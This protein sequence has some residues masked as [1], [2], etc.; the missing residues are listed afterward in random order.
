MSALRVEVPL[1]TA[2]Q[3]NCNHSNFA[4]TAS[5]TWAAP[6]SGALLSNSIVMANASS[7]LPDLADQITTYFSQPTPPASTR[8]IYL[9]SFGLW[10]IYSHA[11]LP[12][13]E[14]YNATITS[15]EHLFMQ[16]DRLA[17]WHANASVTDFEVVVPKLLDPTLL[18]GW[19]TLRPR[20][21]SPDS[22]A[23]QQRTAVFLTKEWNAAVEQGVEQ[24]V[25]PPPPEDIKA[26]EDEL[27]D[28]NSTSVDVPE[29]TPEPELKRMVFLP[30]L[31][32]HLLD[33][34]RTHQ[35]NTAGLSDA[36]GL[37]KE[38]SLYTSV[39]QP[40]L[41]LPDDS[42]DYVD[43]NDGSS[44]VS[45]GVDSSSGDLDAVAGIGRC[46]NPEMYLFW[47]E[48]HYGPRG[49]QELGKMVA[50]MVRNEEWWGKEKPQS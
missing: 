37:G 19:M 1:L 13:Q 10:D 32:T 4:A 5:Q 44:T 45:S 31:S 22:R 46:R 40:C 23:E 7:P 50:D 6:P 43:D 26:K 28:A 9:I 18:P 30:D 29:E 47:D 12:R 38:P 35:L 17:S 24:L 27:R 15:I 2:S 39:S 49:S 14:A 36:S 8:T 48:W 3:L 11:W 25:K 16:I 33:N 21:L 20:P 41:G 42:A 34:L